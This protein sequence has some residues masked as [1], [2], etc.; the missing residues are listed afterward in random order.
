V[1]NDQYSYKL[2]RRAVV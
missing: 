1:V 2:H